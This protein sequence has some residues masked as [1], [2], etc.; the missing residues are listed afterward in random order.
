[1]FSQWR[2]SFSGTVS[3]AG[4]GGSATPLLDDSLRNT[5]TWKSRS[6]IQEAVT[7]DDAGKGLTATQPKGGLLW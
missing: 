2:A 1:M 6:A 3:A 5:R 7:K 4:A